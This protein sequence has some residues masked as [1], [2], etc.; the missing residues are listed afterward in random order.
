[1]QAIAGNAANSL[2]GLG[3][4]AFWGASL[5]ASVGAFVHHRSMMVAN[6]DNRL[7]TLEDRRPSRA[8]AMK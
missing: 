7:C 3:I 8:S 1:L 6:N 4:V 5:L 2:I